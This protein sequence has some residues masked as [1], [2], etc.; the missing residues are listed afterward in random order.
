VKNSYKQLGINL[1]KLKLQ[2]CSK[3]NEPAAHIHALVVV[4]AK[5]IYTQHGS[6]QCCRPITQVAYVL[7]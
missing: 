3:E 7:Q 2:S 6:S 5:K 1:E 4:Q